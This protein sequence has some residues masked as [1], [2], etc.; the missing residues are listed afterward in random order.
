MPVRI[1]DIAKKYG[2]ES[3]EILAKAKTLGIAARVPSSSL[4]KITAE[5]LVETLLKDHPELTRKTSA[6]APAAAVPQPPV[7]NEPIVIVSAPSA[8]TKAAQSK[9][10]TVTATTA[11][12]T[13]PPLA[14]TESEKEIGAASAT[15][16]AEPLPQVSEPKPVKPAPPPAPAG[17]KV[18]DKV[19]FIQLPQK[20]APKA[21]ERA[22]GI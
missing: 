5:Y 8:E 10:G 18:G 11:V 2:L 12:E 13:G 14:K 1:Y 7:V 3:K 15:A 19:G 17:P 4:D 16:I 22:G 20:P 21:G 6:T 9:K